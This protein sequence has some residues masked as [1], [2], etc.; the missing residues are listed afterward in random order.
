ME[1][2]EKIEA[3]KKELDSMT[4]E[5]LLALLELVGNPEQLKT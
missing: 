3:I 4:E 2:R 5:Q 1:R